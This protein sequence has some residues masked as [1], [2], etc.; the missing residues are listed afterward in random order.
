M[1]SYHKPTLRGVFRLAVVVDP[2]LPVTPPPV[3]V[4]PGVAMAN[5]LYLGVSI[6]SLRR[7]SSTAAFFLVEST[8]SEGTRAKPG[9]HHHRVVDGEGEGRMVLM[10]AACWVF[11][12]A[13]PTLHQGWWGGGLRLMYRSKICGRACLKLFVISPDILESMRKIPEW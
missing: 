8:V 9:R 13:Q 1:H 6:S 3:G 5:P 2:A 12:Q 10:D 4:L 11:H 7:F